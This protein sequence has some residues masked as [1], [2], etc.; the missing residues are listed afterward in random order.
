MAGALS[1]VGPVLAEEPWVA[2]MPP[3]EDVLA[4]TQGSDA[5]DTA[6]RQWVAFSNL[7]TTTVALIGDR[8]GAGEMTTAE[9][10]LRDEYG[11]NRDRVLRELQASLPADER[12]FYIGTRFTA[13][14]NLRDDYFADRSFNTELLTAFFSSD[15][16]SANATVLEDVWLTSRGSGLTPTPRPNLLAQAGWVVAIPVLLLVG[17][18]IPIVLKRG[19]MK[20]D[21]SD[22]FKLHLGGGT[23]GLNRVTGSVENASKLAS[24]SV[25]ASGGG[26]YVGAQGGTVNPISVGSSTTV[27]DQFF[28][29]G[30]GRVE[31]IQLKG[32]DFAVAD[33][34]LVSAVWAIREGTGSGPYFV[35]RNHTTGDTSFASPFLSQH[36][37][38]A[39]GFG[40][41][42][43]QGI[44]CVVAAV[45][46]QPLV[47]LPIGIAAAVVGAFLGSVVWHVAVKPRF[48]RGFKRAGLPRIYAEL[49]RAAAAMATT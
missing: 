27:H 29:R 45:V 14:S 38:R 24:T 21:T 31:A 9:R 42:L 37:M 8:F 4:A 36:L 41:W 10:R 47:E 18:V 23:Y 46:A 12:E 15:F 49:D 3:I 43:L 28:I 16:R 25:F 19:R 44:L 20:L 2:E 13:W 17:F 22:P 26:G 1:S 5:F 34:Q 35:L 6:A 33:G 7:F 48:L 11:A 30:G 40:L 32:W 39:S